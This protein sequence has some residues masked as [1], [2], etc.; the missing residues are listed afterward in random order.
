MSSRLQP[1]SGPGLATTSRGSDH[2]NVEPPLVPE[3]PGGNRRRDREPLLNRS[4]HARHLPAVAYPG[5][6]SSSTMT[7]AAIEPLLNRRHRHG[8]GAGLAR[9]GDGW[10]VACVVAAIE[11]R[12]AVAPAVASRRLGYERWR[13]IKLVTTS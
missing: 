7:V 5:Q 3:Q 10:Q 11:Q 9:I 6:A 2:L 8:A 1:R 13:S 4:H 12:L